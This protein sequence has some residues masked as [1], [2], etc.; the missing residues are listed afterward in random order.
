[1]TFPAQANHVCLACETAWRSHRPDD[2]CWACGTPTDGFTGPDVL[3]R[4]TGRRMGLDRHNSTNEQ[5]TT[6]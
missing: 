2:A 1:M 4:Q 3:M 5:G 6:P